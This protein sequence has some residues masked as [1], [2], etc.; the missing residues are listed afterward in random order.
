MRYLLFVITVLSLM[1]ACS[2][3][4]DDML[5]PIKVEIEK[6]DDGYRLLRG[7]EPY[8][9]RGAGMVRNDIERFAAA[10]VGGCEQS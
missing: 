5:S 6:S 2:S 7:G 4:P 8:T 1:T 10:G 9:V 3:E